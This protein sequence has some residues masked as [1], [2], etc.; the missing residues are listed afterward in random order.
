MRTDIHRADK[1]KQTVSSMARR[2]SLVRDLHLQGLRP[3]QIS[4]IVDVN[5]AMVVHD[6]RALGIS[7]E[8][9]GVMSLGIPPDEGLERLERLRAPIPSESDRALLDLLD[10]ERERVRHLDLPAR[11]RPRVNAFE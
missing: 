8:D 2:R 7:V 9:P 4:A 11:R 5:L 1:T 3:V 10:L 6:L